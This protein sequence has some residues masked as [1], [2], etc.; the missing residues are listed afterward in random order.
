MKN[1]I[2]LGVTIAVAGI[3]SVAAN[4]HPNAIRE[5]AGISAPLAVDKY[6]SNVLREYEIQDAGVPA[7]VYFSTPTEFGGGLATSHE[8][9]KR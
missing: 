2:I 3:I 6:E 5:P 4:A 8:Y 1:S 9:M 7:G